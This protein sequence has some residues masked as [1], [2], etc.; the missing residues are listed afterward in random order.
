MGAN[1]QQLI[2]GVNFNNIHSCRFIK[3]RIDIDTYKR[4]E[5]KNLFV[6]HKNLFNL[7]LAKIACT[8]KLK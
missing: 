2:P 6:K 8:L 4:E 3:R 1:A 7:L 5:F